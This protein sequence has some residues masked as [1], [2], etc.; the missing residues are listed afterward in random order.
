MRT[1][2][3]EKGDNSLQHENLEHQ[4][5]PMPQAM[6]IPAVK[7]GVDKEWE[8]LEKIPAWDLTKV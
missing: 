4:F 1:I 8:N 5:I 3:Q 6:K 7:A 2:L